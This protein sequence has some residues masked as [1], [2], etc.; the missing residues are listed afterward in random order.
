[1]AEESAAELAASLW[2]AFDGGRAYAPEHRERVR[3][4]TELCSIVAGLAAR[5]IPLRLDFVRRDVRVGDDASPLASPLFDDLVEA[6]LRAGFRVVMLDGDDE[7]LQTLGL[8]SSLVEAATSPASSGLPAPSAAS[9]PGEPDATDTQPVRV[10]STPV[11]LPPSPWSELVDKLDALWNGIADHREIDDDEVDDLLLRVEELPGDGVETPL[12]LFDEVDPETRLLVHA[13]NV[14][15]LTR[16]AAQAAL[17]KPEAVRA[18]MLA[19]LLADIG[20]IASPRDLRRSDARLGPREIERMQAHPLLGARLL[21]AT[22][23]LPEIV[24]VVAFEHHMRTGGRGYPD[25][26][27]PD[28][29]CRPESLLVQAADTHAAI[30]AERP[31][32]AALGEPEARILLRQL[33]GGWLDPEM[34][35]LLLDEAVPAGCLLP[36]EVDADCAGGNGADTTGGR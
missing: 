31:W 21:L 1:M 26:P 12:R 14:A 7:G 18:L 6:G 24:G 32:R 29:R 13:I 34:V 16:A 35:V 27:H 11:E 19:A 22:P 10:A 4:E 25:R 23:R 28:W 3:R 36:A 15:R 8:L 17:G 20:M 2:L 9:V 30:R 33:A 5:G